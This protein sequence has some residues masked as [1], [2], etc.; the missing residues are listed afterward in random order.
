M[1]KPT[2]IETQEI[3][4]SAEGEYIECRFL[5]IV[6]REKGTGLFRGFESSPEGLGVI[7]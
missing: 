7:L 2:C 1:K 5:E 4:N 6:P 3:E